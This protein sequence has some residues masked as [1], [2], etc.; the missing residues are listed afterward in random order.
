M[1]TIDSKDMHF[2]QLNEKIRAAR[3]KKITV[4]NCCGQRYIADGLGG[5]EIVIRGTPGN[6]LGYYMDGARVTVYGNAQDATGDTMND[7]VIYI[8]GSSGDATGYGMRGGR[9]FVRGDAGYRAGIHMKAYEDKIPVL[10]VGGRAGSFLGEYQAGGLIIVLG[11]GAGGGAPV[12]FFCGTGMH[13]GKIVLRSAEA[14]PNP[15]PQVVVREAGPE[16]LAEIDA[17]LSEFCRVFEADKPAL[18][19]SRFFV[20]TPN[21]LN[22]Y[23]QMYTHN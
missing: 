14:P 20:L 13:G 5:K 12:G 17:H 11:L 3:D 9:I 15:P 2:R 1:L 16:D 4:E 19:A 18:L 22:P 6:G 10:V 21:A 23:K 8:H 7:G